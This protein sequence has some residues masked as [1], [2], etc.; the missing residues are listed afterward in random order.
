VV[1]KTAIK[2]TAVESPR[3]DPST[4]LPVLQQLKEVVEIGQ[5]L[6]GDPADSFVRV[7]ELVKLGLARLVNGTLQPYPSSGV[8][9][10]PV[11]SSRNIFTIGSLV[12]GGNLSHDLTLALDGDQTSPGANMLY[13]T[14]GSGAKGWQPPAAD[15]L[16]ANWVAST[17]AV[18]VPANDVV[19]IVPRGCTLKE[20]LILT[21]GGPGSCTIDI[22]KSNF[23]GFPPGAGGT[24]CGG[25]PPAIAAGNTYSNS[26]LAG[27]TTAFAQDDCLLF[28][29]TASTTFTQVAI[30]LRFT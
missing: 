7:S 6:R 2:G 13:G 28:K 14:N 9:T 30:Y 19:R 1:T 17:G 8:P 4:H 23:A 3:A 10:A 5:R 21:T 11:S 26:T 27:W 25:T 24:I 18:I 20:V 29:I 15:S 16:G 12:G 22:R